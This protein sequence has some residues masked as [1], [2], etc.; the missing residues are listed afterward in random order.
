MGGIV[1]RGPRSA[2]NQICA[3]RLPM[4]M[5]A[6]SQMAAKNGLDFHSASVYVAKKAKDERA[7]L[8]AA[9]RAALVGTTIS[10]LW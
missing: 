8:E 3:E 1:L 7:N 10:V 2:F 6:L 4:R 9:A 5:E